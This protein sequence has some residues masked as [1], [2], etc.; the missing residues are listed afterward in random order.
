MPASIR[1]DLSDLNLLT[2]LRGGNRLPAGCRRFIANQMFHS[3]MR[4]YVMISDGNDIAI[5]LQTKLGAQFAQKRFSFYA[6]GPYEL[7]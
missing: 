1:L 2:L 6:K 7:E 3:Q 5:R 4:P